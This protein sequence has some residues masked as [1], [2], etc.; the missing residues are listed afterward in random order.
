MGVCVLLLF[1][2]FGFLRLLDFGFPLFRSILLLFVHF[3]FLLCAFS[4]SL[5]LLTLVFS[6]V[7]LILLRILSFHLSLNLYFKTFLLLVLSFSGFLTLFRSITYLVL[8]VLLCSIPLVVKKK[9]FDRIF[10]VKL[11]KTYR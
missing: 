1:C 10:K 2:L 11:M 9:M 8:C 4:F 5:F 6:V 7:G 3:V